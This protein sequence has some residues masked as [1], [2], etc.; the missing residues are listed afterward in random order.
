MAFLAGLTDYLLKN[1]RHSTFEEAAASGALYC[2]HVHG[3]TTVQGTVAE[4][5]S[6]DIVVR[7]A[8][9]TR[10]E[11]HKTAVKMLYPAEFEERVKVHLKFDADVQARNLEP[12]VSPK[13][14]HFLKNKSL[15][16]LMRT[17]EVLFITLLEGEILR[18]IIDSFSRY[19][20]SLALKDGTQ[21]IILRHAILDVRNKQGRCFLKSSQQTLRDWTKSE[22]YIDPRPRSQLRPGLK[23]TKIKRRKKVIIR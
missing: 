13:H 7:A 22:L 6:Y 9:G 5:T 23:K 3:H 16:P 10:H 1:Y 20:I 17:Q 11:M 12:I 4:N 8:D 19:E 14:R 18:G 15:F 21:V 2:L